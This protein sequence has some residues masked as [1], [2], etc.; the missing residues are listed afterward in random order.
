MCFSKE[1][2]NKSH[3]SIFIPAPML[4]NVVHNFRVVALIIVSSL[5]WFPH[6]KLSVIFPIFYFMLFDFSEIYMSPT[7]I[8]HWFSVSISWCGPFMRLFKT[9]DASRGFVG[10]FHWGFFTKRHEWSNSLRR[11]LGH[12]KGLV[13]RIY[14]FVVKDVTLS[15]FFMDWRCLAKFAYLLTKRS[16]SETRPPPSR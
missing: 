12:G 6:K 1:I 5:I 14:I 13:Q 11:K 15:E 9:F 3:I 8:L 4:V 7:T 2:N 16:L 10:F